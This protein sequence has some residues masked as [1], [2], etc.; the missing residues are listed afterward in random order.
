MEKTWLIIVNNQYSKI[1]F[2]IISKLPKNYISIITLFKLS[3]QIKCNKIQ[4]QRLI[5]ITRH[6]NHKIVKPTNHN[7][8]KPSANPHKINLRTVV[9]GIYHENRLESF[10]SGGGGTENRMGR[11]HCSSLS[12]H[13]WRSVL[14]TGLRMHWKHRL[15]RVAPGSN[16]A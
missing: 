16:N 1:K 5:F 9:F 7:R 11:A 4:I 13:S 10:S 14:Y 6:P 15:L 8:S 3:V 12:W 2:Q